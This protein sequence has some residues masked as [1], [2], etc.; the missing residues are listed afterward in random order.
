VLIHCIVD[1]I[2]GALG[3][4]DIGQL[5]PDTD[6]TWKG[7]S[8]DRFLLEA[9]RRCRAAGYEIGNLDATLIAQRP[10]LS[11]HKAAIKASLCQLMA[12]H[13][14]CLNLKAKTHE[15]VDAVGEERAIA[16]HTVVLLY[17]TNA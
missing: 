2:L 5:F 16:C 14:D 3:M 17:R 15:K 6:A 8:S 13:P 7:A 11:P 1:A 9:M 4:P 12:I 10:K